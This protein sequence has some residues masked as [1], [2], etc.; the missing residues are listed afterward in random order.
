MIGLPFND[1]GSIDASPMTPA[2][3]RWLPFPDW[4]LLFAGQAKLVHLICISGD[5]LFGGLVDDDPG[6]VGAAVICVDQ[7]SGNH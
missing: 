6:W 3:D 2:A 1:H 7:V 4:K 5:P